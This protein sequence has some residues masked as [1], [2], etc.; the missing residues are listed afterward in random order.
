MRK[1]E[2]GLDSGEG[3]RKSPLP[4]V[5]SLCV[6]MLFAH[7]A[8]PALAQESDTPTYD[9]GFR[10]GADAAREK[11]VWDWLAIGGGASLLTS[12]CATPCI[13]AAPF[14]VERP[15]IVVDGADPARPPAYL[16]GY[17]EGFEITVKRRRAAA[18]WLGAGTVAVVLAAGLGIVNYRA[19]ERERREND[20]AE[21]AEASLAPLIRF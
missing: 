17:E 7:L 9:D 14:F 15:P 21:G 12:G 16:L 5:K 3:V 10:A 20:G 8:S 4:G 19:A 18:A 2:R 6:A 1:K 11:P 13:G